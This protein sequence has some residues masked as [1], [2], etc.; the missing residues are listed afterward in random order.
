MVNQRPVVDSR[1][2]LGPKASPEAPPT[3]EVIQMIAAENTDTHACLRSR[4]KRSCANEMENKAWTSAMLKQTQVGLKAYPRRPLSTGE[5]HASWLSAQRFCMSH[6]LS[7]MDTKPGHA[8][9]RSQS[10]TTH[11]RLNVKSRPRCWKQSL[12]SL[13]SESQSE[14]EMLASRR[15]N[16]ALAKKPPWTVT[17]AAPCLKE[18]MQWLNPLGEEVE[19]HWCEFYHAV[20]PLSAS[21][22]NSLLSCMSN[23]SASNWATWWNHMGTKQSHLSPPSKSVQSCCKDFVFVFTRG[24][25]L[26]WTGRVL[27]WWELC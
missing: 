17:L 20:C 11:L 12:V 18:E 7:V 24:T 22:L 14:L 21:L 16:S 26:V 19:G 27:N 2:E 6:Y 10:P 3:A 13:T 4:H 8:H 25:V 23:C 5:L 9:Q 1:S 15:L